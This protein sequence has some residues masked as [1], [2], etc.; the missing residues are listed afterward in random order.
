MEDKVA[1]KAKALGRARS[2]DV[3]TPVA[4]MSQEVDCEEGMNYFIKARVGEEDSD[5]YV[6]LRIHTSLGGERNLVAV[7]V[8][9]C[10]KDEIQYFEEG[11]DSA[12]MDVSGDGGVMK[13]IIQEGT[14][15]TPPLGYEVRAHYTGTLTKTGAKFDSS[16]EL[17]GD[18]KFTLGVAEVIKAWDVGFASMKVGERAILTCRSDYAYGDEGSPPTIPGGASLTFDCELLGFNEKE[19]KPWEMTLAEKV[20]AAEVAKAKGTELFK[21]KDFAG[22]LEQYERAFKHV[23]GDDTSNPSLPAPGEEE[24]KAA[25]LPLVQSSALNAAMCALKL[26][27]HRTCVRYCTSVLEQWPSNV[28]ALFR[29]GS[30][31]IGMSEWDL[32]KTDLWKAKEL[33]GGIAAASGSSAGKEVLRALRLLKQKK[34]EAKAK[35]KAAFGGG[36]GKGGLFG[37]GGGGTEEEDKDGSSKEGGSNSGRSS[38]MVNG[39][40]IFLTPK[41]GGAEEEKKRIS[42][43]IPIRQRRQKHGHARSKADQAASANAA[44]GGAQGAAVDTRSEDSEIE[45]ALEKAADPA[46]HDGMGKALQYLSVHK[47]D[48][49]IVELSAK[50]ELDLTKAEWPV[51]KGSLG[52]NQVM[53]ALVNANEWTEDNAKLF[54][55]KEYK[56]EAW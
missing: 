51:Q 28:K 29:R 1:E 12:Q 26:K 33:D 25:S 9:K 19:R 27:E 32:A 15:G 34:Q 49:A 23:H 3:L 10:K 20:V 22:A 18:F 17:K 38:V 50:V 24:A 48:P 4:A 53:M 45:Q 8:D 46:V 7:Q 2:I 30:A 55:G 6:F 40:E 35:A 13:R 42:G 52:V 5:E 41:E 39:R 56:Y 47:A 11:S 37:D 36:F 21:Q 54:L 16:R 43:D 14:G 31:Y 44:Q